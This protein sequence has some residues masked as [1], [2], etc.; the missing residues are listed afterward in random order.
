MLCYDWNYHTL[1]LVGDVQRAG[2]VCSDTSFLDGGGLLQRS[3]VLAEIGG[4]V[5]HPVIGYV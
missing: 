1:E 4:L 3:E 5:G 2:D